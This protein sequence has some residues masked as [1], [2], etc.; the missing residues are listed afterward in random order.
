MGN[1]LFG[2]GGRKASSLSCLRLNPKHIVWQVSAHAGHRAVIIFFLMESKK[3][4]TV[5]VNT[6]R[7]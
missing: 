7:Q 3:A 6:V 2:L 4:V 5:K 1:P